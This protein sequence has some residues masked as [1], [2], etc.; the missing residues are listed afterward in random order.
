MTITHVSDRDAEAVARSIYEA[1][2]PH[3]SYDSAK[4][5]I[6]ARYLEAARAAIV[7]MRLLG[8]IEA[9]KPPAE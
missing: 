8:M 1:L 3:R 9:A 4:P 7:T 6:Q 5:D 2:I